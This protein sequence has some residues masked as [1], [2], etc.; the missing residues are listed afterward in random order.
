MKSYVE[1]VEYLSCIAHAL[2]VIRDPDT[3]ESVKTRLHAAIHTVAYVYEA[4]VDLVKE[5]L[6]LELILGDAGL[7]IGE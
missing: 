7:E 3:R 4:E 1:A 2:S 6:E 5:D